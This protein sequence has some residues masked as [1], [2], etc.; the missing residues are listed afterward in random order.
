MKEEQ[1]ETRGCSKLGMAWKI[2]TASFCLC[3]SVPCCLQRHW[4]LGASQGEGEWSLQAGSAAELLWS[5]EYSQK[6]IRRC[7]DYYNQTKLREWILKYFDMSLEV[8]IETLKILVGPSDS[9]SG[10]VLCVI[11]YIVTGNSVVY[12]SW[13][14]CRHPVKRTCTF[15]M[16]WVYQVCVGSSS[17]WCM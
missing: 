8:L 17:I 9:I 1:K 5:V 6:E 14:L 12:C 4:A 3:T 2:L 13:R 10:V 7:L 16:P 11:F 15:F